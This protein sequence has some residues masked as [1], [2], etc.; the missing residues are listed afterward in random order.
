[1]HNLIARANLQTRLA[2]YEEG[3]LNR[4]LGRPADYRSETTL[5]RIKSVSEPLVK[6]LLFSKETP[7]TEK[8]RGTSSFA[9]DFPK[10]G[11]RDAKSRSLRDFDLERRLFKYPCSYLIYSKAFD[12]MPAE[13]KSYVYGRMQ[14][15]LAGRDYSHEFDHLTADD[16]EAI[17]EILLATKL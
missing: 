8:V 1:M 12:A 10:R 2:L 15:V 9:D 16:R 17:R 4:E 5:R 7:L 11:P 13:V 3:E 14:E 6:Y